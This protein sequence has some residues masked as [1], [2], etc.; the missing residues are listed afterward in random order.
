MPNRSHPHLGQ[1][2]LS[3]RDPEAFLE[4]TACPP[5]LFR[6]QAGQTAPAQEE[7]CDKN[8]RYGLDKS[9]SFIHR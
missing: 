8:G 7:D 1:N 6:R 2:P 4:Q 3:R 9:S 5:T